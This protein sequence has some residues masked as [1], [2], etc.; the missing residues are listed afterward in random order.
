MSRLGIREI[1]GKETTYNYQDGGT[2]LK[3]SGSQP[4]GCN[5]FGVK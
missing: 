1:Y 5:S 3:T 4:V 2:F